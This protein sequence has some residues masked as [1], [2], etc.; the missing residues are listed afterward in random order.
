MDVSHTEF[1]VNKTEEER[2]TLTLLEERTQ[3]EEN[4]LDLSHVSS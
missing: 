1:E 2:K 4:E 3:E